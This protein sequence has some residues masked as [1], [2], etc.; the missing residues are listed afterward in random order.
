MLFTRG[1]TLL[2][3]LALIVPEGLRSHAKKLEPYPAVILPAGAGTIGIRRGN[4]S[5][6]RTYLTAKRNGSWEEVDTRQLMAPIAQH[7]FEHMTRRGFGLSLRK[8]PSPRRR[9]EVAETK[10]W[11][12]D[13]LAAQGFATSHLRV[14]KQK[15]TVTLQSGEQRRSRPRRAKTYDL[16]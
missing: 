4:V 8:N 7:Y 11:M 6:S 3:A 12:R 16:D 5:L 1:A 9:E 13:K 10:R 2:I 14:M 15:V